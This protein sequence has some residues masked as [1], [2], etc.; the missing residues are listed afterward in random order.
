MSIQKVGFKTSVFTGT[1]QPEGTG[2]ALARLVIG[3]TN[4][5]NQAFK[6]REDE[7]TKQARV[8]ALS[9]KEAESNDAIEKMNVS[10]AYENWKVEN[11]Y[12]GKTGLEIDDLNKQFHG[13]TKPNFATEKY[14]AEH[15]NI[16]AKQNVKNLDLKQKEV[17]ADTKLS[18]QEN[19]KHHQQI[20]PITDINGTVWSADEQIDERY[21]MYKELS[22]T[23][24]KKDFYQIYSDDVMNTIK[25]DTTGK[26]ATMSGKELEKEFSTMKL[27]KDKEIKK[28]FDAYVTSQYRR[29]FV[30]NNGDAKDFM[31]IASKSGTGIDDTYKEVSKTA[32]S[33]IN[34][35]SATNTVE[36]MKSA[37]SVANRY[38]L[39]VERADIALDSLAVSASSNP[40]IAVNYYNTVGLA[41]DAGYVPKNSK[42][43]SEY[44]AIKYIGRSLGLDVTNPDNMAIVGD[45]FVTKSGGRYSKATTSQIEEHDMF[46]DNIGI[47]DYVEDD[48]KPYVISQTKYLSQFM[49]FE[50]ALISAI[51]MSN[52]SVVNGTD[53]SGLKYQSEEI[54]EE[55]RLQIVKS[56]PSKGLEVEDI[57]I[58]NLGDNSYMVTVVD[59]T[60][61]EIT[62]T[63]Q[64]AKQMNNRQDFSINSLNI[65]KKIEKNKK[66]AKARQSQVETES[67]R[68]QLNGISDLAG[69]AIDNLNQSILN[70]L[71]P[72]ESKEKPTDSVLDMMD[73]IAIDAYDSVESMISDVSDTYK[74]R[75][76]SKESIVP[77]EI[78][79]NTTEAYK[80]NKVVAHEL[81]DVQLEKSNEE[82][83]KRLSKS[84]KIMFPDLSED[85]HKKLL[86]DSVLKIDSI[87]FKKK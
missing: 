12:E 54:I 85:A 26:Y 76:V 84:I 56:N 71:T 67:Y 44:N 1:G 33:I 18:I 46:K 45:M 27:I 77:K 40:N 28:E 21:Q 15:R 8:D 16:V 9:K 4:L 29:D 81:F 51:E 48:K 65:T 50:T 42:S 36:G 78:K 62:T 32:Q 87:L 63:L 82:T 3:S 5:A 70:F 31:A 61:G 19:A 22:P 25:S 80:L 41:I 10:T 11:N 38:G 86:D 72:S 35:N 30:N 23:L 49:P 74:N 14:K 79:K 68:K 13:S 53:V 7:A 17:D 57:G 83:T 69:S 43:Y 37:L 60:S 39:R 20:E 73:V 59:P 52:K 64:S 55:L 34:F 58:S 66:R 47:D 75:M 24:T 6:L 2:Q